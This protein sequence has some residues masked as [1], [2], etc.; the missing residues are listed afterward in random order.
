MPSWGLLCA[1]FSSK[2]SELRSEVFHWKR[3]RSRVWLLTT[4]LPDNEHS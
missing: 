3:L 2:D 1:F 4:D